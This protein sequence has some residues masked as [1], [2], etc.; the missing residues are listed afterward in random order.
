MIMAPL[1]LVS[2]RSILS[3]TLTLV[4]RRFAAGL[5][6]TQSACLALCC[7]SLCESP[8]CRVL[9]LESAAVVRLSWTQLRLMLSSACSWPVTVGIGL[10]RWR[11]LLIATLS[12]LSTSRFPQRTLSALWPQC[13]LR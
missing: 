9:L 2:W 7:D 11:V 4:K 12:M 5:L 6:R 10:N 3:S 8:M 13:P 1:R